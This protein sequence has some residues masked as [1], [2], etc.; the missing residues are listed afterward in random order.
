MSRV[1]VGRSY[2][3]CR[4]Y[5]QRQQK[6]KHGN[7]QIHKE[8]E[9]IE[10]KKGCSEFYVCFETVTLEH[11]FLTFNMHRKVTCL[12]T[13]SELNKGVAAILGSHLPKITLTRQFRKIRRGR[14]KIVAFVLNRHV[15]TGC[16]QSPGTCLWWCDWCYRIDRTKHRQIVDCNRRSQ[17]QFKL[18]RFF[19]L[20]KP[21]KHGLLTVFYVNQQSSSYC[22]SR[23]IRYLKSRLHPILRMMVIFQ[24][25]SRTIQTPIPLLAAIKL[26]E[27]EF[28]CVIFRIKLTML[29]SNSFF[30]NMNASKKNPGF[31]KGRFSKSLIWRLCLLDVDFKTKI[32]ATKF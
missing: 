9:R 23:Q 19:K 32:C 12:H 7:K 22:Q 24:L 16:K 26:R 20:P 5:V 28:M 25:A 21:T 1:K 15:A 11:S 30:L 17:I 13:D 6:K 27:Q 3:D 2:R 10:S 8:F 18:K 29:L 14:S 31:S 4:W